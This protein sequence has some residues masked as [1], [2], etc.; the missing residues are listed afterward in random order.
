MKGVVFQTSTAMIAGRDVV[1]LAIHATGLSR[2]PRRLTR[3]SFITPL[4]WL[5]MKRQSWL[6]TTVGIAQGINIDVRT[7]PRPLK[8]ELMINAIAIP[9]T[10]SM[11][12]EN[13]V[14]VMV[15]PSALMKTLSENKRV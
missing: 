3:I 5:Y 13:T 12:T 8:F 11:A 6:E 7:T 4:S 9:R 2:M 10:V 14:K 1:G 15:C